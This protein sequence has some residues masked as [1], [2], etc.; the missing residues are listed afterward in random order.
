M[1]EWG[2]EIATYSLEDVPM[3]IW[4]GIATSFVACFVVMAWWLVRR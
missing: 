2:C 4:I 3:L 1:G